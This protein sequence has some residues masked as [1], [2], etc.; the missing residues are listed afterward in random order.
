MQFSFV[1]GLL[2]PIFFNILTASCS[3]LT[4]LMLIFTFSCI[5]LPLVGKLLRWSV[6]TK[7]SWI[8]SIKENRGNWLP[9]LHFLGV[10][11]WV[12]VVLLTPTVTNICSK[13]NSALNEVRFRRT[14]S[15]VFSRTQFT[16][17]SDEKNGLEQHHFYLQKVPFFWWI[18]LL[19][20]KN[21]EA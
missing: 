20:E 17:F 12:D 5:C 3:T 2:G 7:S 6:W 21:L 1:N 18:F 16:E 4:L 15:G 14:D 10:I 8:C 13:A 19:I 9:L 11:R